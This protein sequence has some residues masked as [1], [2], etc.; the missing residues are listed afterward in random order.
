MVK[1]TD[2]KVIF[3]PYIYP[4]SING[5]LMFCPS[6]YFF[7]KNRLYLDLI[8]L[9]LYNH[10]VQMYFDGQFYK[11]L[12]NRGS[13]ACGGICAVRG[14]EIITLPGAQ[15]PLAVGRTRVAE[16]PPGTRSGRRLTLETIQ[17]PVERLF[18]PP[19]GVSRGSVRVGGKTF[20]LPFYGFSFGYK[21]KGVNIALLTGTASDIVGH[22]ICANSFRRRK[23]SAPCPP[24]AE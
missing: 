8:K 13:A 6:L 17:L 18:P 23:H 21:R 10:I 3:Y 9:F 22:L 24:A 7:P 4:K 15:A 5:M 12:T 1:L 14:I 16:K 11:R 20:L 19:G 2:S